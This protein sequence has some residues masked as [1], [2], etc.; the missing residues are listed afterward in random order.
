MKQ[1]VVDWLEDNLIGNP[2]S[3]EDFDHNVNMFKKAK[4][5]DKEQKIEFANNYGFHICGYDYENAEQYYNETY[6]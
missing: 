6:K 3:K 1:T 5:M 2:F 4:E